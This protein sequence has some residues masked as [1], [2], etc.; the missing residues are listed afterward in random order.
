MQSSFSKEF[1]SLSVWQKNKTDT[2]HFRPEIYVTSNLLQ[3]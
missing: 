3:I 1:I 2:S